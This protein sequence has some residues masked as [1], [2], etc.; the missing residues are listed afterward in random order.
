MKYN[1]DSKDSIYKQLIEQT[2]RA[3]YDGSLKAGEQLPS[4]NEL[5]AEL[6]ISR[7]TVKKA[8][9]ILVDRGIITPRQGRGFFA[10]D[11]S[12]NTRPQVL[13]I[14]DKLSIYKQILFNSFSEYLGGRAEVT[15]L[16][17]NQSIDL[18][19][20]YLD[21]NLDR[22]DYYVVAP[23]F[24][25]SEEVQ[26]RAVKQLGRIP[27]R[28][29]IMLDRLQP[30][31]SGRFGAVYQDFENDICEG[32]TQG[33]EAAGI[34]RLRVITLPESLYGGEICKGV[35]RFC[36]F[37]GIPVEFLS[38]A[39]DD[40]CAGDTFLVLNSQLDA[41]LVQLTHRIQG[42]KL[43][44]GDDVRII[45][46]NEFDMNE[47]VLGGLTTV[48]AD[49]RQMGELAAEMILQKSL[50]KLHCPFRLTRRRTF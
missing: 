47:L 41:G 16:T 5:A 8:Y 11:L 15:I 48:S 7:E 27:F 4:M 39:P 32:L 19:E 17:H 22:F 50:Q 31:I 46:Y 45:S 49:F 3:L 36:S 44:V 30:G 38:E 29:L 20:Y 12:A 10:S 26:R 13:V 2:E 25:L 35:A 1:L 28:K 23:H 42:C 9:G 33:L 21:S 40:I 37:H 24:P 18:F 43:R 34:D 6:Q 14:F